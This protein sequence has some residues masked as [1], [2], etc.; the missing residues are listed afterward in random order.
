MEAEN[1]VAEYFKNYRYASAYGNEEDG[2]ALLAAKQTY[3]MTGDESCLSFIRNYFDAFLSDNGEIVDGSGEDFSADWVNGSRCLFL[4]YDKTGEEKYRKAIETVMNHLHVYPRCEC[5]NFVSSKE[6][7]GEVTVE[8]L[9]RFQPFYAE[10]ETVYDKKEKYN[11]IINQFENAQKMLY[12][13]ERGLCCQ[14]YEEE[15]GTCRMD[16]DECA[17]MSTAG[18]LTALVDT[19]ESMSIEIYEQYRKLQDMF[20]LALKGVLQYQDKEGDVNVH[21]FFGSASAESALIAYSILKACRMGILLKEKYV[22]T[23][24]EIV[25][26]LMEQP[27]QNGAFI[28]ACGEYL[29]MKKE[30]EA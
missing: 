26:K 15:S 18:Y 5:G 25:E 17:F 23:G 13:E 9:Y 4:L 27:K 1:Y 20:K 30:L 2:W 16:G 7:P 29:Q 3:E 8:A 28:M 24:M 11:D 6:R 22:D 14:A 19:M 21:A 10:Y 12:D